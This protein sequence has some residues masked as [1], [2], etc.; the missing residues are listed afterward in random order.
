MLPK[1][2]PEFENRWV[3]GI[4][5]ADYHADKTILGSSGAKPLVE[6]SAYT[7]YCE[8]TNLYPKPENEALSLGSLIHMAVL[9][10]EEFFRN[11]DRAPDFG[12]GTTKEGKAKKKEYLASIGPNQK[13]VSYKDYQIIEGIGNSI[14]NNLVARKLLIGGVAERTG[15]YQ[16][17]STHIQCKIRPDY[18][19]PITNILV[20]LKTTRNCSYDA[21]ARD[22]ADYR[23]DFQM[24]MYSLGIQIIDGIRP[25]PVILAV[26]KKPPYEIAVYR[27]GKLT[28]NYGLDDYYRAMTLLERCLKNNTWPMVDSS[29]RTLEL[30]Q[31]M[32]NKQRE[33]L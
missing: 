4:T 33:F 18:Y 25:T 11:Y 23:Y 12:D 27:M 3:E 5:N 1:I 10:P 24:A 14:A 15:Y 19:N 26:E 6:K 29:S 13:W 9:E 31:W 30:P 20:D 17:P 7:F 28:I 22:T 32:F 16:D 8:Y 21:F 2:N